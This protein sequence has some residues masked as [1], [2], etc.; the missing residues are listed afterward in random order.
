[1]AITLLF[2]LTSDTDANVRAAACRTLGVYV[3]FPS[4]REDPLF[5][6][7]MTKAVLAQKDDKAIVVR[8]RA[9]WAIANMCDALVLER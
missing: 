5:V 8:V 2:S 4:L 1:M 7:D 3:L 6:S 9:T